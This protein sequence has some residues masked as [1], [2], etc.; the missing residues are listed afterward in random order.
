MTE[1]FTL[2][3]YAVRE[4]TSRIGIQAGPTR[5]FKTL[6]ELDDFMAGLSC[7]ARTIAWVTWPDGKEDKYADPNLQT[8]APASK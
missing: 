5:Q 8:L 3:F 4:E 7:E 2:R 6:G 1:Q